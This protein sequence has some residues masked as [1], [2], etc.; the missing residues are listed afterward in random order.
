MVEIEIKVVQKSVYV[1]D[2]KIIVYPSFYGI[3]VIAEGD[4]RIKVSPLYPFT[5]SLDVN[6]RLA[7]EEF[8][9]DFKEELKLYYQASGKYQTKSLM[10]MFFGFDTELKEKFKDKWFKCGVVLN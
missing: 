2:P 5:T 10:T 8:I 7:L 4:E 3:E 6:C 1:D 9:S